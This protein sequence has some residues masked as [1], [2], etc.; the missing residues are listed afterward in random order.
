MITEKVDAVRDRVRRARDNLRV[1]VHSN[2]NPIHNHQSVKTRYLKFAI[3][4]IR[5]RCWLVS[6]HRNGWCGGRYVD[7]PRYVLPP[8][9][10]VTY[11]TS[12]AAT[13]QTGKLDGSLYSNPFIYHKI[14][15]IVTMRLL[16]SHYSLFTLTQGVIGRKFKILA[17]LKIKKDTS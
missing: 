1:K 7:M 12:C 4:W 14:E 6:L 9:N 10:L 8:S 11:T 13:H 5:C 2:S 17:D 15:N 3:K 16:T